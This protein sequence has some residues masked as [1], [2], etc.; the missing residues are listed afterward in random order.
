MKKS[1]KSV[2]VL[3][4]AALFSAAFV[5]CGS[6]AEAAKAAPAKEAS[7]KAEAAAPAEV[8]DPEG[9]YRAATISKDELKKMRLDSG[10]AGKITE[11]GV[12]EIWGGKGSISSAANK[13]SIK[14]AKGAPIAIVSGT[15]IDGA[16]A[17]A[18]PNIGD[19]KKLVN[20]VKVAT[21]AA[22]EKVTITY[23]TT[24]SSKALESPD[25]S[26]WIL[27]TDESGKIL[28]I[29]DVGDISKKQEAN[30]EFTTDALEVG[31]NVCVGFSRGGGSGSLYIHSIVQEAAN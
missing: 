6:T 22:K 17:K 23:S 29:K 9:T 27:V 21:V 18:V 19:T 12:Y 15:N 1:V 25:L 26:Y 3:A 11:E 30:A 8:V 7:A 10:S 13:M 2:A 16:T 14:A 31:A 5:S 20:Y 24:E 28:A 4:A